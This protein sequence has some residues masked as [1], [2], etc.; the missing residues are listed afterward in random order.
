M[1]ASPQLENG[2]TSI[3]NEIIEALMRTN[4]SAYQI[5]ILWGIWRR[6]YG[7]HKKEDWL[8]NSQLVEMTGLRKQHISRTI[9]ELL[10]RN[11][12]TKSGYKVA[13]NKDY[14]QWRESPK[15]V[16][17]TNSGYKVTSTGDHSNQF[18]GTQKKK[19]LKKE[20]TFSPSDFDTFWNLYPKRN[21][22]KAG[23]V[24]CLDWCEHH[25]KN[26]DGALL[27]QAVKNYAASKEPKEGFARDP[28]RFLKK[29]FWQDFIPKQ[30]EAEDYFYWGDDK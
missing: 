9:K 6:T 29:D 26:G 23:K 5:R 21:G 18:R 17:V 13:F 1:P 10:Q 19:V 4:L 22:R 11:I 2:Y 24:E 27:L 30:Q 8:S 7:F 14:T 3:A 28:I 15:Q 12:V 25:L 20:S 16:T